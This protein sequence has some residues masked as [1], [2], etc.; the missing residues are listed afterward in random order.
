LV[1]L[2]VV[3]AKVARGKRSVTA[4]LALR[5]ERLIE[6]GVDERLAGRRLSS[7]V[8]PYCGHPPVD[9]ADEETSQSGDHRRIR[10]K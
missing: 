4:R 5:V 1:E 3:P 6:V 9:F 8:R 7:R 2:E 10:I